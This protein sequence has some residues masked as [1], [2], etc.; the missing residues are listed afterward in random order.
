MCGDEMLERRLGGRTIGTKKRRCATAVGDAMSA[1]ARANRDAGQPKPAPRT[2]T[3]RAPHDLAKVASDTLQRA[4]IACGIATPPGL[5]FARKQRLDRGRR[6]STEGVPPTVIRQLVE[7]LFLID[8]EHQRKRFFSNATPATFAA[9]D[10]RRRPPT[11]VSAPL[12]VSANVLRRLLSTQRQ[13]CVADRPQR[14]GFDLE[15]ANRDRPRANSATKS[16]REFRRRLRGTRFAQLGSNRNCARSRQLAERQMTNKRLDVA[17][18]DRAIV[19][20]R[21]ARVQRL[22]VPPTARCEKSVN[23]LVTAASRSHIFQ[24]IEAS[25]RHAFHARRT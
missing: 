1:C 15:A 10:R 22:G 21:C 23:T 18:V 17:S 6:A 16:D 7:R 24:P 13:R 19:R 12:L 2:R 5:F 9:G 8:A 20:D 3:C 14:H 11:P 25:S 4:P